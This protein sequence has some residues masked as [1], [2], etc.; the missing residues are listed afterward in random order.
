MFR[1]K[2]RGTVFAGIKKQGLT[3][4]ASPKSNKKAVETSEFRRLF[5]YN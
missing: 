2:P 1:N 5:W 3:H 4:K